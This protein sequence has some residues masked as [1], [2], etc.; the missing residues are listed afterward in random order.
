MRL[1]ARTRNEPVPDMLEAEK[2]QAL[3][4]ADVEK[5]LSDSSPAVRADTASKV[6]Q[7]FALGTL[8]ERERSVATDIFRLLIKD[9]EVRVRE[10]LSREVKE[11]S[12]LPHDIAV[13]LANDVDKVALPILAYSDVLTD[14]D[15]IGIIE[16]SGPRKQQAIATRK[17]VSSAVS[18]ALIEHGNED[19][20]HLLV[21][22]HGADL[23]EQSLQ[24][25]IDQYGDRER[26]HGPLA[27]RPTL[28]VSVAER[29]VTLVSENLREHILRNHPLPP[30]VVSDLV[31]SSREHATIT[32]LDA[33]AGDEAAMEL[34]QSLH[35]KG[36]LT[37]S[38]ILRALCLGD[39]LFCE[40]ALA[41]MAGVSLHNAQTLI[42]DAGR[43][44]LNGIYTKARL[45]QALFPAFR[46]AVDVV[47]EMEYDGG[48]HDR[49]RY[50]SRA[51]QRILT[52]Y[53]EVGTDDLD[54]L[55]TKLGKLAKQISGNQAV[56]AS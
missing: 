37:P 26:L 20:V 49:E 6:A 30:E 28:P 22:N 9:A 53:E 40:A 25:L 1:Y 12:A 27:A 15:L 48:E 55:L 11:C 32:L 24:Q 34:V 18:E 42:H 50:Q 52:Q 51:I 3:G 33:D 7:E 10:A 5:L 45:P 41:V 31:V 29:L 17:T 2:R 38:I 4:A 39:L 19:V 43:L 14:D 23:P 56:A 21:S 47:R 8:S 35:A 36:R 46:V 13:A 16:S 54:Y 44:G